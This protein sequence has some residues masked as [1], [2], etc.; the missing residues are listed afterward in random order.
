MHAVGRIGRQGGHVELLQDSK[1]DQCRDPLAVGRYLVDGVSA[2][3][4]ADRSDPV[5]AM[6]G[7]VAGLHDP[8]VGRRMRLELGRQFSSVERFAVGCGDLLESGRVVGKGEQFARFRSPPVRHEGFG[9]PRLG[10]EQRH[11][12]RPLLRDGR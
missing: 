12:R 8:A 3:G 1:G 6:S 9:E 4:S 7:Q 5:G 2:V 11:L 10:L